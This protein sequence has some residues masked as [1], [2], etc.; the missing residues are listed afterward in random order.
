MNEMRE[1][2]DF[3]VVPADTPERWEGV[4]HIRQRVFAEEQSLV[5]LGITDAD[6]PASLTLVGLAADR[7]VSTGRLTPAQSGRAAYLSWIATLPEYR[8]RGYGSSVVEQ[9]VAAADARGYQ[10]L[11]LAA[12][13][14][15]VSLYMRFGFARL[16][17]PY[18]VRGI[19]HQAMY[20]IHPSEV[21]SRFTRR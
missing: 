7:P 4:L 3:R 13:A 10:E 9:L 19:S 12:Q 16:G 1:P 11:Q 6:D 15:A 21:R 20:R 5:D 14:H 2:A 18:V 17:Q 8:G